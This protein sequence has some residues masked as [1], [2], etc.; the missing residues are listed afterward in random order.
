MKKEFTSRL[1]A[2]EW[3]ANNANDEAQFEVWREELLFNHI[4][5]NEFYISSVKQEMEVVW[6]GK[7]G[8]DSK[9]A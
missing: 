5:T 1:E 8:L 7:R 9:A 4:Y 2:I 3:I 6:L